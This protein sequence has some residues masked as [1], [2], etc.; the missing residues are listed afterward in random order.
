MAVGEGASQYYAAVDIGASSGRVL[1]GSVVDGTIKLEEVHRFDNSQR[2][3]SGH[4]C[5]DVEMLFEGILMGLAACAKRGMVP[6]SIG[7]D[8]WGCDF[9]LID[10]EGKMVGD[11]VAYRDART[12]RIFERA[13][14]IVDPAWL[15]ERAG[16]Q[17]QPFNTVYQLLALS[18]EH[19]EQL[20]RAKHFLMIPDYLVWRLTGVMA[21]EYANATT[22][23]MLNAKTCDW[24]PEILDAIGV[25]RDLFQTP[26]MPGAV[27]GTLTP[28]IQQRVGFDAKVVL[29]ASHDTG[30]AYLAVPARDDSSIFLSSGTWSLMGV[31]NPEPV[32]TEESRAQ[33]FTN[34]GG[35]ERR[36]RYLKNIMGLWMIQSVRRE[37]NGVEY[38]AGRHAAQAGEGAGAAP[39]EQ[40][41]RTYGFGDLIELAREAE[42]FSALVDVDADAF[43]SPDSMIEAIRTEC[44]A[45][46]QPVPETPGEIMRTIYVSLAHSYAASAQQLRERTGRSFTAINIIGGGCQDAYLDQLCAD[47]CGLPV[48]AGPVE[49]TGLGNLGVQMIAAGAFN[50]VDELRAAIAASFPINEFTPRA[51]A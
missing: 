41:R 49:G 9:V 36:Y 32:L 37:L 27:I 12:D 15:Y 50:S 5:W 34:E 43:L 7:I 20:A 28:E 10:G 1:V 42:P 29:P 23:G 21:N 26:V 40:E 45:G 18:W 44:A 8:T 4:D 14:K 13:D 33:N 22:T 16:I 35:Y 48:L 25:A 2:R 38:V 3:V 6:A 11:A 24:D 51:E 47:A 19:P 39:A 30:S 46:G 31:E 17:R